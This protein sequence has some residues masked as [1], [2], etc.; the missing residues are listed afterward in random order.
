LELLVGRKIFE[1][2]I[3]TLITKSYCV[4]LSQGE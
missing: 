1:A 3:S 2:G 4:I